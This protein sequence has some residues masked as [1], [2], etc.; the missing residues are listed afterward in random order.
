M[1]KIVIVVA[2]IIIS[3]SCTGCMEYFNE[4]EVTCTVND[5]WIKRYEN[6]DI[7]LVSCDD[8]VYKIEDLLFYGKFDSS[9]MYAKLKKGKKYKLTVTGYRMSYFSEYQNINKIE[10]IKNK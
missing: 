2:L 7:Y 4:R 8:E 6:N 1:K 3:L 10:E 9:N 5:K